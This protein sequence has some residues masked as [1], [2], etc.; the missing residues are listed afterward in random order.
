MSMSG[1]R[2]VGF[3]QELTADRLRELLHYDPLTGIFKWLVQKGRVAAGS[4]AGTSDGNGYVQI[5]IDGKHYRGQRLAW[6]Y[7]TGEWPESQ[8]DHE[9]LN[10]SDNRWENLRE[11][12]NA[13]NTMNQGLRKSN[14]S[15]FKGVSWHAAA[16]AWVA[17]IRLDARTTY[18]GTFFSPA[19]AHGAY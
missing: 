8:V 16:K 13:Q 6:C 19:A 2:V 15:G 17:N 4:V 11:A 7:M 14:T 12:S 18:L 5:R 10:R 9:K 1:P 3:R